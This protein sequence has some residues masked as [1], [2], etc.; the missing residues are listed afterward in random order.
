MDGQQLNNLSFRPG[1][2]EP[3]ECLPVE[4][5]L[6]DLVELVDVSV[7][8][9]NSLLQAD[10]ASRLPFETIDDYLAAGETAV[11]TMLTA[12]RSFGRKTARELDDLIRASYPHSA[13][14]RP[15][16]VSA[17]TRQSI[18]SLFDNETLGELAQTGLF[19]ARLTNL[20]RSAE[21]DATPF[22][23]VI[24][25]Y[26]AFIDVLLNR[27]NCGRKSAREFGDF[28]YAHLS[29]RLLKAGH[30]D[31]EMLS[32]A[33]INEGTKRRLPLV[34]KYG[35][36]GR[37]SCDIEGQQLAK[38]LPVN[39][40][41]VPVHHSQ[42]E[43]IEWLMSDARVRERQV[44]YRRYGIG[45]TDRETLE[46]IGRDLLVT[47]ERVRQLQQKLLRRMQMR[48]HRA[49]LGQLM[50]AEAL[51]VWKS[52]AGASPIIRRSE[53]EGHLNSLDA[54][55]R[56]ALDLV[57]LTF[58]EWLDT[59]SQVFPHGWLRSDIDREP[60]DNLAPQIEHKVT[61]MPLPQTFVSLVESDAVGLAAI[62][63]P[64]LA[65]GYELHGYLMPCR[66]GPRLHR[67]IRLHTLA[68]SIG[69]PVQI[70]ELQRR[71]H[72]LFSDYSC[73]I[74]DAETVMETAAHMFLEIEDGEWLGIGP[75]GEEYVTQAGY[76]NERPMRMEE[77][78]TNSHALQVAL[79]KRGPTRLIDLLDD[80]EE[81]LPAGRSGNSIAPTLLTRRDLFV[82]VLP[83]VYAL[84]E[85]SHSFPEAMSSDWPTLFNDSQA[86]LYALARFAGEPRS[87][88]PF[89]SA[90]VEYRLCRWARHSGS[91]DVF[92]S[93]LAI[94]HID[95]WPI[96]ALGKEEWRR[97]K[98]QSGRFAIGSALRHASAYELPP[99]DRLAA[100]CHYA[101]LK[102]SFNWVAANR[103]TNRKID[104]HGGAGLVAT[105]VHLGALEEP[106]SWGFV[107]QQA[108]RATSRC[109]EIAEELCA[110][111]VERGVLADWDCGAGARY[112]REAADIP[113]RD[114]SWVDAAAVCAMLGGTLRAV[115]DITDIDPLDAILAD[116]RRIREAERR[117][118]TLDWL[119]EN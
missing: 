88:F 20:L 37:D 105:M 78:G 118:A 53:L 76:G 71:Y 92:S 83:G 62:A 31:W 67:L 106:D 29:H 55:D 59:H 34:Q 110:D 24:D 46:E 38:A 15:N 1:A 77:E 66:A 21:L 12:V 64:L 86:K 114:G 117:R 57:N 49:P 104:W 79:Q 11:A 6:A 28:A 2:S 26:K 43:R 56:L 48:L 3:D 40:L 60:I 98:D 18:V 94:A 47:R 22:A 39:P 97:Q 91:A 61:R 80:W 63:V 10:Q 5:R 36:A 50:R 100:A 96:D 54:Y 113:Q 84:A 35:D 25:D 45:Q 23:R 111:L 44:L 33:L 65:G 32:A 112:A 109:S 90:E 13:N 95:D 52:V 87:I 119:L 81:I 42:F 115:P 51:R 14:A 74:R 41:A 89:W 108:H 99:L 8:L 75:A 85:D 17:Q 4:T 27:P 7:R 9:R 103:I 30:T 102:G 16:A 70:S 107:W 58:K 116:Q 82:R 72:D 19:S 101:A 68:V 93:L 69:A 73:G